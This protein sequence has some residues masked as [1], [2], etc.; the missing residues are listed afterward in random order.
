MIDNQKRFQKKRENDPKPLGNYI[1]YYIEQHKIKKSSVST[2]L[3]VLP[4]TLN[5]YFKQSS[6]QF[7]I[8]WRISLAV[9]HNFI[10]QLGEEL[11]IP[12]ETQTE[13]NLKAQLETLQQENR[14]LK[15]ENELLKDLYKR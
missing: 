14:D 8:L 11:P 13:K 4:T 7:S 10:M 3:G 9:K 12:Y 1:K 5:Q 6:F 15:R 2:Y